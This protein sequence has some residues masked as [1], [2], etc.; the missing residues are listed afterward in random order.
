MHKGLD[1]KRSRIFVLEVEAVP[2][3]CISPCVRQSGSEDGHSAG[4][5]KIAWN[6]SLT[7]DF[8]VWCLINFRDSLV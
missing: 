7:P 8:V 5:V 1:W 6:Q 2:Q 4:E 3:S